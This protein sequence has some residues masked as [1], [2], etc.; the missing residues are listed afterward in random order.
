MLIG[1]CNIHLGKE[2]LVPIRI[3]LDSG[4]NASIILE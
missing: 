3:L 2:R 4:T 1:L